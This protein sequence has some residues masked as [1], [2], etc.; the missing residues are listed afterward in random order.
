MRILCKGFNL[1]DQFNDSRECVDKFNVA[2]NLE[3]ITQFELGHTFT[4]V[5]TNNRVMVYCKFAERECVKL[6]DDVHIAQIAICDANILILSDN[7]E[8]FRVNVDKDWGIN[9][10]GH[11]TDSDDRV[12]F[13]SSKCKLNIAYTQKGYLYTIPLKLN[14]T[15]QSLVDVQTGREHC[16]LL[17]N[18]GKVYTFGA[19][20]SVN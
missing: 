8:I 7:G 17:D 18:S 15:N 3:Q 1:Y 20:R 19:G 14:F 4:V 5:V 9:K 12:K 16:I 11:F 2:F 6:P 13:I 10:V